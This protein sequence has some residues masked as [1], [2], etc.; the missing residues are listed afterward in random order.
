MPRHQSS[1]V[2]SIGVSAASFLSATPVSSPSSHQS[3][4]SVLGADEEFEAYQRA[5]LAVEF[6]LATPWKHWGG[7]C[8]RHRAGVRYLCAFV[9]CELT[10]SNGF[11]LGE[12]AA[13]VT[14]EVLSVGALHRGKEGTLDVSGM[15]HWE[16][17]NDFHQSS[18]RAGARG[19]DG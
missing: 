3:S 2:L 17:R 1:D 7:S 8:W 13:T 9:V 4:D 11:S 5:I 12:Y 6:A 14:A 16:N 19:S 18:F 15:R 10:L